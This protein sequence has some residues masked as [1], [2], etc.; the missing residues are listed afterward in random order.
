MPRLPPAARRLPA[1]LRPQPRKGVP[2]TP[3]RTALLAALLLAAPASAAPPT[4]PA[5]R[6]AV[7][8]RPAAVEVSPQEVALTGGR[9]ARQLVITGKYADGTVRDLTHVVAARVEPA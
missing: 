9:D 1:R 8:G 2:M 7:V 6:A 3:T 5:D 4:D